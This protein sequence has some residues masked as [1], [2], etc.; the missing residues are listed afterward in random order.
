MQGW[1]SINE[2][3]AAAAIVV[4]WLLTA[5]LWVTP[6]LNRPDGAGY[7]VYLPS[8]WLDHDLLFFD[9]WAKI[10]L[11]RD[12]QILFKDV[13]STGHLSNHWTAGASLAW[14]PAFVAGDALARVIGEARDGFSPP[15]VTAIVFTSAVAGLF[16]LL[17]GF[18][19]ARRI[20]GDG[21][22]AAAAMAIW[23]GSPLAFYGLR[24]ASMSHAVSAAAC[25]AVVLLSLRL[26]ERID[27]P[28]LF[29]CGLA[30]GFAC[31]V[32]PQN[33]VIAIVP[34]LLDRRAQI[35]DRRETK[36]QDAASLPEG[37][38]P[39]IRDLRSAISS[40]RSAISSPR[41]AICLLSGALLAALPQLIVSQ[42]LW[43]APLAF[44][45]IG[46]TAHP[47]QMFTTFRPFE[48]IFSWYH[49]LATWTPLV[50]VAIAGFALLWRDDR[51]LARAGVVTFLAQWL[52]LSVLERWFWGGSSFG[53]RRF[54]SCSIF[55]ILGLA[56]VL[57]RLPRW[58]GALVTIAATGWTVAL[59]IASTNLNLNRYQTPGELLDAFRGAGPKWRTFLGFAPPQIHGEMLLTMIVVAVLAAIAILL[60]R[61]HGLAIATAYFVAMSAFYAWCGMHPKRDDFSNA[62]IAKPMASGSAR[63][64]ATLLRYEADYMQRTGRPDAAEKALREAAELAP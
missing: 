56:A 49:G 21:A 51:G 46:G 5:L 40:P 3:R 30:I 25:A 47:W 26:R 45:N 19:I 55:F 37:G 23:L 18:R 58:L 13:T 31:A 8:T 33:V 12:G 35:A 29:A 57:R 59:F 50:V 2:R 41:S 48:T 27:A 4:L 64:T 62:L 38:G 1:R 52:V 63:D 14:Y 20:Y 36:E 39:A 22:A 17:A 43:H 61:R 60:T 11:I 24:H 15:Y 16:V 9:E 10:G 28:R 42:T 7:F 32:R 6:G 54:D 53:Q 44:V 34:F